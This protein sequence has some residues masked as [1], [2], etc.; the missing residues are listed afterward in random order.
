[1]SEFETILIYRISF[2]TV[3]ATH[4]KSVK[5]QKQKQKQKEKKINKEKYLKH[6]Q[7]NAYSLL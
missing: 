2:R 5:K 3:S 7:E 6:I 4:R 1:M